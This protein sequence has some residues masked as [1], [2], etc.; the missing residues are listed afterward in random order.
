[1]YGKRI[2]GIALAGVFLLA[3]GCKTRK[4]NMEVK[5]NNYEKMVG[6]LA[7][8]FAKGDSTT[9]AETAQFQGVLQK[10]YEGY[11]PKTESINALNSIF[12]KNKDIRIVVLGGNWCSDTQEGIPELCKVL[13][14]S[15]FRSSQ[16]TYARVSRQKDFV[17]G[18]L[19]TER[20]QS[21]PWV[22][23]YVDQRLLGEIVEFPKK[24]WESDLLVVLGSL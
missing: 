24:S 16:F 5:Q 18:K 7:G 11:N 10:N 19:A 4:I 21:V 1:M 2:C 14:L 8:H 6:V 3:L 12:I 13:D 15:N 22:R 23:I 20:I 9:R 17:D